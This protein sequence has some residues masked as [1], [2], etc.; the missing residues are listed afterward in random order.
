MTTIPA[1]RLLYRLAKV[2]GVQTAYYDMEHKRRQAS[3]ESLLSV[4]NS[5]GAPVSCLQDV[6]SAL[7]EHEQEQ[8]RR[9]LE[10][11]YVAWDGD[12]VQMSIRLAADEADCLLTGHL[13]S[14]SGDYQEFKL[15][16]HDLPVLDFRE[17]EGVEYTIRLLT[18]PLTLSYGYHSLVLEMPD[19]S[20]GTT[21]ISA[22]SRMY[23][24]E[25]SNDGGFWGIF[26]PL[27]SL[28]TDRSWGAGDLADLEMLI[29]W[30]AGYG[31]GVVATLPLLPTFLDEPFHPS[32]Y[33]PVTRLAWNEFYV[34]VHSALNH[35]NCMEADGIISSTL[36]RSKL[37]QLRSS[38]LV[39]YRTQMKLKREVL[40]KLTQHFFRDDAIPREDFR[41]FI[42]ANPGLDDYAR[43]RATCETRKSPWHSWPQRLR[44]GTLS[45]EDYDE[46]IRRY[47]IYTQWLLHNQIAALAKKSRNYGPGLYLDYA[48]GVHPDG[49]DV[50]RYQNLFVTNMSVGAPPDPV[51]TSG[52]DWG[53]PPLHPAKL[54]EHGY[55]YYVSC[56]RNHLEYAGIL[57]IDH[58]MG[59]H[60]LFLIPQGM[61]PAEGVYVRYKHDEFYAILALESYR[62]RTMI[63]GEDLGTVPPDVRPSMKRHGLYR[64]YVVQ[65]ELYSDCRR[66]LP[67]VPRNVVA[68]INTHDM[69]TFAAFWQG[70]DLEERLDLDLLDSISM[71]DEKKDRENI[72]NTLLNFLRNEGWRRLIG[73][74]NGNTFDV[75]KAILL[76]LGA[77]PAEVVLVNLED[78]WLETEPQNVPGTHDE[79]PNWRRKARYSLE[80]FS[81]LPEVTDVLGEIDNI[82]K[83]GGGYEAGKK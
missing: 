22:P 57:R 41:S 20:A 30:A 58:V 33:E 27:Y 77:S 26:L 42:E 54:R 75:L 48:L 40:E 38:S 45:P 31:G 7:R 69:P 70:I 78:L 47:Y 64:N 1:T 32:P 81:G 68:G 74:G 66:S 51:F 10:P 67:P 56:V 79:R 35:E 37:E 72:R 18:L 39:D 50:W 61:G 43:F 59:L 25:D 62:N 9:P 6:P 44:D 60:R 29:E 19:N 82:R 5:L 13:S 34:D 8:W 36:F 46:N 3:T 55:G 14:E 21:M 73:P 80:T 49:Y 63:V 4:L 11:V 16:C 83:K 65:Y 23:R 52:Q 76:F 15:R 2:Y 17:V 24:Y 28:H 53:F 12:P 71:V